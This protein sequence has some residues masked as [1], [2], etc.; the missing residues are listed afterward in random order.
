MTN[1]HFADQNVGMAF[2]GRVFHAEKEVH[3][4]SFLLSLCASHCLRVC[5]ELSF[6]KHFYLLFK[7]LQSLEEQKNFK[8]FEN[9]E[10]LLKLDENYW[11]I[12]LK[13]PA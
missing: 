3:L 1:F 13:C 5:L 8:H 12:A 4:H 6:L 7:Y 10:G 11:D 2:L 9:T